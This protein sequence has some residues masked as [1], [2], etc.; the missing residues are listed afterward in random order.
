MKSKKQ[1]REKIIRLENK[2]KH[3]EPCYCRHCMAIDR[4][5]FTLIWVLDRPISMNQVEGEDWQLDETTWIEFTVNIMFG[6]MAALL[7]VAFLASLWHFVGKI[8]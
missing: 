6:L 1:I 5:Q 8:I 4:E 3:E 7:A 2:R